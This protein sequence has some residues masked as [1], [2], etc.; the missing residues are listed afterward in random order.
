MDNDA[1]SR[2]ITQAKTQFLSEC[3]QVSR[4]LEEVFLKGARILQFWSDNDYA[5][6]ITIEDLEPY[7]FSVEELQAFIGLLNQVKNMATDQPVQQADYQK[8]N[9]QIK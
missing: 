1:K 5:T 8:I 3:Q 9:N 6:E 7:R 2:A 4:T